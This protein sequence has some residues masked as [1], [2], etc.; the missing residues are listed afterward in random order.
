MRTMGSVSRNPWMPP[1]EFL[2]SGSRFEANSLRLPL[3][4]PY[5]S[6]QKLRWRTRGRRFVRARGG[7]LR[8]FRLKL[9]TRVR[10]MAYGAVAL[11]SGGPG[12]LTPG[13]EDF[14]RAPT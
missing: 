4:T 10:A 11:G 14:R 3:A 1:L 6:M 5:A 7:A 9:G 2:A 13:R 12:G 8:L